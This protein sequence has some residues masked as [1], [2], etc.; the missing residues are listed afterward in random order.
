MLLPSSPSLLIIIFIRIVIILV[1][2]IIVINPLFLFISS[3]TSTASTV[4]RMNSAIRHCY[5]LL[6]IAMYWG[7][8]VF[9]LP[10]CEAAQSTSRLRPGASDALRWR[11]FVTGRRLRAKTRHVPALQF[12]AV[13]SFG[14][15]RD[16]ASQ[17][18]VK[19]LR[20]AGGC[21]QREYCKPGWTCHVAW[22]DS[23]F[24]CISC[25]QF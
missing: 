14:T 13:V 2:G 3:S 5:V 20:A 11:A 7:E 24:F 25:F 4:S 23:L 19:I 21:A 18:L 6:C 10:R 12:A 8:G 16:F 22:Q 15:A 17:V 9:E 1:T